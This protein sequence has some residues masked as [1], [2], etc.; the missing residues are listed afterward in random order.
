M[1]PKLRL[2]LKNIKQLVQIAENKE[3]FKKMKDCT[4][5]S[6]KKNVSIIVDNNGNI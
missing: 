4:D 5:I 2:Y 1:K 3:L 6:I